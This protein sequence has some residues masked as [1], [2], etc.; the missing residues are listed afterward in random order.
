MRKAH[1]SRTLAW[2]AAAA[3]LFAAFGDLSASAQPAPS[4]VVP[5]V[6]QDQSDCTNSNVRSGDNDRGVIF[7]TRLPDGTTA[8][9][10]SMTVSRNTTYHLFLKCVRQLG[11]I[12]TDDEGI[13]G[14]VFTFPTNSVGSTFA[15]DMYPEGAPPGNKFQSVTVK[16]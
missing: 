13:G 7:V 6:R 3:S 2:T 15:F 16:Y 11:D 14:G 4:I 1:A 10:V 5:L 8:A 12:K 9:K